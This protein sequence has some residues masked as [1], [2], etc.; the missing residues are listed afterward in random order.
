M[1]NTDPSM[2]T[3]S[4]VASP[5]AE[6]VDHEARPA[7]LFGRR[8]LISEEGLQNE[9]GHWYE[10]CKSVVA[11]HEALGAECMVAMHSD[12]TEGARTGLSACAVYRR[13]SW[14]GLHTEPNIVKRY[15]GIISQ[16][17]LVYRTIDK[18]IRE[19]GPF[20]VVFAP[21]VTIHHIIGW[22]WLAA[23]HGG[24]GLKR[25]VLL[26]RNNAGYYT[27]DS[28]RPKFRK[29]TKI[30]AAVLRSFRPLLKSGVAG[31]ATDSERLAD[32]YE[33]LSTIRPEVFASPRVAPESASA[34]SPSAGAIVRGK[35][36]VRFSCLGP[37]RFEKGI[38][39]LQDAI[40]VV[41]A[42]RESDDI[43]F[44]IQWNSQ[45]LDENGSEYRPAPAL[46]ADRRVRF[47]T[48]L[49][50]SNQYNQELAQSDCLVL[51]YRRQSYFARISGVAV[52]GITAGIPIIYTR[53]TW[54][55]NMVQVAGAGIGVPDGDVNALVNA[56]EEI[57]E[58]FEMLKSQAVK[59][60]D[61]AR[62]LNS[63]EAFV[64]K[65]WGPFIAAERN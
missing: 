44:V 18:L 58:N 12:A 8:L 21:T 22:R 5:V 48:E 56:I 23:R 13:S 15:C 59:R 39:I 34:P 14:H 26:F 11:I 6:L 30:F 61:A 20:D 25:L 38:D 7:L 63:A 51:P 24:S 46:A 55:E 65:L 45:I 16:N 57:A 3:I 64:A 10:Y 19:R 29:A 36:T 4:T 54:C 47:L 32:E 50:S 40:R 31:L 62:R 27:Q 35:R 52:E 37:A 49:L 60:A 33:L 43:S 41:L 1:P 17:Y 28:Q 53:D 42:R 9:I 2:V